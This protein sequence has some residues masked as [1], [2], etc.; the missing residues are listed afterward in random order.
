MNEKI[1][2]V[3]DDANILA[4]F[5]R[6]LRRHFTIATALGGDEA[7]A[8]I[9]RE[10][11]FA[12][13]VADMNMPGMNGIQLLQ[14]VRE[15]APDTTRMMLTGNA[16]QQT[17]IDAIN[18]GYIFRF[19][20]KPC[21]PEKLAL[22]LDAGL[23]QYQ[24]RT[25]EREL[26]EK[27]LN[28]SIKMLTEILSLVEPQFF[29]KGQMLRDYVRLVAPALKIEKPWE[30]EVAAMLAQV[31]YVTIP[32]TIIEKERTG[33]ALAPAEKQMVTRVPEIGSKLLTLIPRMDSVAKILLYQ[34]KLY[35]GSGF[36]FDGI[37]GDAIPLGARLL[38]VLSD[39]IEL[40]IGGTP[41]SE[42]LE[43]MR[44]RPGAYDPKVI[45]AAVATLVQ[46]PKV[47]E[48]GQAV[49]AKELCPGQVLLSAVQTNDGVLILPA[50][51]RLSPML[52]E[53][54]KNFAELSGIKEPIYVDR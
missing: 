38:R 53:K 9:R 47:L 17:A 4:A 8:L 22:G 23:E 6:N 39:F 27:T 29:G 41:R 11:P 3:D 2:C 51:T 33:M 16:D 19:L 28:G 34:G 36:P 44:K 42:I 52:L 12:V 15:I 49:K 21:T 26:L 48:S 20:T 24:L 50:G 14:R 35:D 45:D 13:I 54:L 18:Q 31:G 1:L 7:L 40:E 46:S 32:K 10:G 37:A 43:Q 25:A 30:L 5:Q